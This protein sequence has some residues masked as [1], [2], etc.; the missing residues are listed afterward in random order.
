MTTEVTVGIDIGTSS[1]KALAA[2]GDG[3]V[4]ASARVPHEVRVPSPGAGGVFAPFVS[5]SGSRRG[6]KTSQCAALRSR[7][8]ARK[9]GF[10]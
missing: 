8:A 4:I 9:I 7:V 2:D 6:T 10:L 3:N 1:V 5:D